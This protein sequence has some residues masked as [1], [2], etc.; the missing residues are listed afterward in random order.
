[1]NANALTELK[2]FC[3]LPLVVLGLIAVYYAVNRARMAAGKLPN[4]TPSRLKVNCIGIPFKTA[5]RSFPTL[6]IVVISD[7]I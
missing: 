7:N 5:F 1:M 4:L 2:L 6:L 3:A